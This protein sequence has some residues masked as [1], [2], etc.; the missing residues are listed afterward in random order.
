MTSMPYVCINIYLNFKRL[1][2]S[3]CS[4]TLNYDIRSEI[5]FFPCVTYRD[6]L[7]FSRVFMFYS[8]NR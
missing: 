7:I 8:T 6:K 5:N 4:L 2:I 1:L 3:H